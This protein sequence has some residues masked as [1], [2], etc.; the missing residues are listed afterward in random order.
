MKACITRR[1]HPPHTPNPRNM[2]QVVIGIACLLIVVSTTVQAQNVD[3]GVTTGFQTAFWGL[4]DIPNSTG[5]LGL[6]I[7][8]HASIFFNDKLVVKPALLFS[9]KGTWFNNVPG[10]LDSEFYVLTSDYM[11]L[12]VLAKFYVTKGLHVQAGPQVSYLLSAKSKQGSEG[13]K[14]DLK[15]RGYIKSLD[16]GVVFGLGYEFKSTFTLGLNFD[17]SFIDIIKDR[18]GLEDHVRNDLEWITSQQRFPN[19]LHNWTCQ[20]TFSYNF[21]KNRSAF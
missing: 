4:S 12:P 20:L 11:T 19:D 8:G 15:D 7:G 9:Q 1:T 14:A 2:K 16:A 6:I 21:T 17:V 13:I 3:F 10:Q 5:R 18:D